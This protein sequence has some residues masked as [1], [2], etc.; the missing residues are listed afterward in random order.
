[1]IVSNA[2]DEFSKKIKNMSPREFDATR[3]PETTS[4]KVKRVANKVKKVANYI[5]IGQG[6]GPSLGPRGGSAVRD[7]REKQHFNTEPQGPSQSERIHELRNLKSYLE[8]IDGK[9]DHDCNHER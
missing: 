4:M 2:R 7:F 1:M 3:P 5:G 8:T 9:G 6:T